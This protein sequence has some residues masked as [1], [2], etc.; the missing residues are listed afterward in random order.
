MMSALNAVRIMAD[1]FAGAL[2]SIP[3]DKDGEADQKEAG[4]DEPAVK[5]MRGVKKPA[6]KPP[7]PA[8][9]EEVDE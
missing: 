8:K 6:I 4:E 1:M 7:E 9:K 5:M 3:T 2:R